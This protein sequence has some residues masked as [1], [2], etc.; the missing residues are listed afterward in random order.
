MTYLLT[1]LPLGLVKVILITIY[2]II[3]KADLS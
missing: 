1:Y 3:V 2:R